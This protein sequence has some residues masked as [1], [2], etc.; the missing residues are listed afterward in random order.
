MGNWQGIYQCVAGSI[1]SLFVRHRMS[2]VMTEWDD[3]VQDPPLCQIL[4]EI[5]TRAS[6]MDPS[7]GDWCMA[8]QD[9]TMWVDA[10]FLASG[11]VIENSRSIAEDA[12]WL[13][14]MHKNRHIYLA[15]LNA[16]LRGINLELQWKARVIHLQKDSACV[17]S[18]ISDTLTKKMQVHTKAASEMLIR[19]WLATLQEL[20][21]S[22]NRQLM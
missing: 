1:L 17:H 18:W 22:M 13:R 20:P 5:I 15:E 4:A 3:E 9:V 2:V 21:W 19:Y 7:H 12:S 8:R 6:Q 11:V 14:L 10:S 16:I